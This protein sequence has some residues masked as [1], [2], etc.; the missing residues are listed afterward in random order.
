MRLSTD[1]WGKPSNRNFKRVADALLYSL[2]LYLSAIMA[3]PIEENVK[4]WLN[5]GVTMLVITIKTIS[6]LT[7]EEE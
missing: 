3:L 4:T 5:F 7:A 6:K 2:P 1:N